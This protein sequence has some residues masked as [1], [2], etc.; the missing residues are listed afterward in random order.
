[1]NKALLDT[2]ILSA[3]M[4]QNPSVLAAAQSYLA[5]HQK[6]SISIVTRFEILRGLYAKQGRW[7]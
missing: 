2:D 7:R 3:I 4:R 5:V 6:L 1:M